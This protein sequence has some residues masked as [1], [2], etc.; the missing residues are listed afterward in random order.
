MP[1]LWVDEIPK[2][3]KVDATG[4][5]MVPVNGSSEE[6]TGMSVESISEEGRAM[7]ETIPPYYERDNDSSSPSGDNDSGNSGGK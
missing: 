5:Y 4:N 7:V 2:V 6:V 3:H 1:Y